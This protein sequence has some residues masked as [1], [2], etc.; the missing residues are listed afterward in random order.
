M[1]ASLFWSSSVAIYLKA[2][3][4]G[5]SASTCCLTLPP[6][7]CTPSVQVKVG[8]HLLEVEHVIKQGGKHFDKNAPPQLRQVTQK[9]TGSRLAIS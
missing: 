2:W 7:L 5:I 1:S 6:P 9:H 4:Q 3:K 8:N